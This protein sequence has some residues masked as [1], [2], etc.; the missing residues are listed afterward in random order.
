MILNLPIVDE[1]SIVYPEADK[2]VVVAFVV[3]LLTAVRFVVLAVVAV[4]L[5]NIAF[6][7]DSSDAKKLVEVP[8]V[9]FSVLTVVVLS[10][11]VPRTVS[12]PVVEALPSA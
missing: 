3:V 10:V 9:R 5:V 2:L 1:A 11:V 12:D 6:A 4:K 8:L 7:A